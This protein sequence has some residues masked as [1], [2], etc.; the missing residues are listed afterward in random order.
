VTTLTCTQNRNNSR[1]FD[2]GF[3]KIFE[4]DYSIYKRYVFLFTQAAHSLLERPICGTVF[5]REKTNTKYI[6]HRTSTAARP[7]GWRKM[8]Q[9]EEFGW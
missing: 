4:N 5:S 3:S 7:A 9:P 2:S 6:D 8:T 1:E